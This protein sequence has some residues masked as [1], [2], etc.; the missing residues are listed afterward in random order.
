M[1]I[2]EVY[3]KE[4]NNNDFS[5]ISASDIFQ[6]FNSNIF[7]RS[8]VYDST[9]QIQRTDK[10]RTNKVCIPDNSYLDRSAS[11]LT[12]AFIKYFDDS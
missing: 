10:V 7:E 6:Y 3:S 4:R 12:D 11:V 8:Y 9:E 5:I 2:N 1:T